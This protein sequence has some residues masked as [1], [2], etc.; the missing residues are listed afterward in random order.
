[1][2]AF[3]SNTPS[4]MQQ[5]LSPSSRQ[6]LDLQSQLSQS[7]KNA[8]WQATNISPGSLSTPGGHIKLFDP[9]TMGSSSGVV[10]RN[11]SSN[12]SSTTDSNWTV[13][14]PLQM[15][16]QQLN[17]TT[18]NPIV[19]PITSNTGDTKIGDNLFATAY[20]HYPKEVKRNNNGPSYPL[21]NYQTDFLRMSE[22]TSESKDQFATVS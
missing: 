12:S 7:P 20:Q 16:Q 18:T 4:K 9:A 10:S 21:N 3:N 8:S 1:M 13:N 14:A 11:N 17:N 22:N 6:L 19:R 2:A 5:F 15:L